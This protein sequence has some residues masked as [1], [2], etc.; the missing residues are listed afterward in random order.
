M[1]AII[2]VEDKTGIAGFAS[3]LAALGCEIV[4]TGGTAAALR[5]A[6]IAAID[7]VDVT[8]YA[9]MLDGRVKTLHPAIHGAI[10][11]RRDAPE[12]MAQL[13]GH[14]IAP[15]DLV[16]CN[17]YDFAGAIARPDVTLPAAIERIDIGGVALL[18]A[19][20]KNF[21]AVTVVARVA[22]Y[23]AVLDELRA[24]GQTSIETR[25][26]L[27]ATAFAL[28][29]A[30]DGQIALYLNGIDDN[31]FPDG[32][33]LPLSQIASMRYG[34]NPH[35][36]AAFYRWRAPDARSDRAT[37]AA[38]EV[39]HGK[40]LGYNNVMDLD[41]A[42]GI[43]ADF[44][45]PAAAIV[46]HAGPCGVATD[47][48]LEQAFRNALACDPMSA[49]GGI[50]GL[51]REVDVAT[52]TAIRES[53]FDAIV[54]PGFAPDALAALERRKN[55]ILVATNRPVGPFPEPDSFAT[56]D[57]RRVS[58]GLLVQTPNRLPSSAIARQ[59]VTKRPPTDEEWIALLFAWDVVKHVRSNAIVLARETRTVG[60]GGGQPNR[61]DAVRIAATRAGE[62][63]QGAA[64]ASDAYFPFPD[65]IEVA[66]Q[67]G[68]TAVIQPGGSIRDAEVVAAA[69]SMG[70]A[71][72]FTGFRHFRH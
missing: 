20:A 7:V 31:L 14:G 30:Y 18:R 13:A 21:A 52:A 69:D 34:E 15:I 32:L 50:I 49:Y 39:L 28:T 36:R 27:A 72:V 25:R 60:I 70:L 63:A 9:E 6:G 55:L 44:A 48:S 66:A 46:K 35:Q 33:S 67:A 8:G 43:V 65:N 29:A 61:V 17:L 42:L 23:G 22:D 12:H 24:N 53:H 38:A 3:G 1:R 37:I 5:A 58:G 54:A 2:S 41:A 19:A 57:V 16:I 45:A 64:L 40:Q 71:M 11:A 59:V 56:L 47:A 68:V 51:N 62:R 26:R 4:S 10:L